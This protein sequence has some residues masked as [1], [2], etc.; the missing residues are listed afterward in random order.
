MAAPTGEQHSINFYLKVDSTLIGGQVGA[1]LSESTNMVGQHTKDDNR[2]ARNKPGLQSWEISANAMRLENGD[3]ITGLTGGGIKLEVS[4][5]GGS[6]YTEVKALTSATLNL[7]MNTADR[8]NNNSAG[9]AAIL[10]DVREGS[11]DLEGPYLDPASTDGAGMDKVLTA[12]ENGTSLEARLT[13]GS[14][15][16]YEGTVYVSEREM[17][18]SG[19][20]ATNTASLVFDGALTRT[21]G[22]SYAVQVADDVNDEF[23]ISGDQTSAFTKGTKFEA[24]GSTGNDGEYTVAS[25]ATYDGTTNTIIPVEENVADATGDGSIIT[26]YADA[27]LDALM[28]AFFSDPPSSLSALIERQ[29]DAGS[30]VTGGTK[31]S[32]TCY[33]TDFTLN[34]PFAEDL[35]ADLTLTGDGALTRSTQA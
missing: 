31:Q 18:A 3:Q 23:E 33:L 4:D 28:D 26:S 5:D 20:T 15:G 35:T 2:W 13:F 12:K 30:T 21:E 6:T 17:D 7:S 22:A 19:E 25:D 10:P 34:L 27:G 24:E 16:K 11:I 8:A 9:W 32:G 29:D 14:G 1:T